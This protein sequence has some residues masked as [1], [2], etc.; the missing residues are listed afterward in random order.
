[1]AAVART[2]EGNRLTND[3]QFQPLL[4]SLTP[5]SSKAVLVHVGRMLKVAGALDRGRDG[6]QMA[7]V[8]ELLD[9]LAVVIVTQEGPTELVLQAAV[10][11]LPNVPKLVEA[12][13][14]PRGARAEI[15]VA[16]P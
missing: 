4:S 1:M 13:S 15:S 6:P 16:T 2:G 9:R 11:G 12:L 10:S 7:R 14:A 3:A 8:G 5:D